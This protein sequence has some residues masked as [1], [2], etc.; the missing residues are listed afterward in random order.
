EGGAFARAVEN[1]AEDADQVDGVR[2]NFGLGGGII[3]EFANAGIGP[4]GGFKH[5]LLLEHLCGVLEA[6]VL[7][8]A[9]DEFAAGIFG[10]ILWTG[11]RARKEHLSLDVNEE[12]CGV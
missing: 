12:G 7:E 9:L 2:R 5:L 10:G 1:V 8:E 6:F 3:F 4:C 11:G